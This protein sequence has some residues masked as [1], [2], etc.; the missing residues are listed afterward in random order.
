MSWLACYTFRMR[1]LCRIMLASAR[2]KF[3]SNRG[4]GAERTKTQ[5][6]ERNVEDAITA[7]IS[8]IPLEDRDR[9][10]L[11]CLLRYLDGKEEKARTYETFPE[12]DLPRAIDFVHKVC[13]SFSE[14]H[15]SG[16]LKFSA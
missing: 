7:Y 4:L 6:Y 12:E 2:L 1:V 3:S 14:L 8:G 15:I 11:Q 5:L 9:Q 10:I 16:S 13:N